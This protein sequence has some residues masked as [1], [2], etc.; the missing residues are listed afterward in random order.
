[1]S[2]P[3]NE[4]LNTD[5]FQ[6]FSYYNPFSGNLSTLSE[7]LEQSNS[8]AVLAGSIVSLILALLCC[9]AGYRF[10]RALI[11]LATFTVGFALGS[12]I[13][14]RYLHVS[15]I[16]I[17]AIGLGFGLILAALSSYIY[18]A[19][20]FILA[21]VL[22]YCTAPLL[23]P[24]TGL[25][26]IIV[27]ALAGLAAGVLIL[28]FIRQGIIIATAIFGATQAIAA[29]SICLPNFRSLL[30]HFLNNNLILTAGC[31]LLGVAVQLI[32]TRNMS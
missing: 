19:G 3:L 16:L 26:K 4:I 8:M 18:K 10:L 9:F 30:P 12:F 15:N 11:T 22:A 20:V 23:A 27:C 25:P 28:T 21:F 31:A 1:M 2:L 5:F 14:S 6:Y 32:S 7:L 24:F 29:L 13:A 17:L